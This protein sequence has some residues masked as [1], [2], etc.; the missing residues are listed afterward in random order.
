MCFSNA[1]LIALIEKRVILTCLN[2]TCHSYIWIVQNFLQ[3]D[4]KKIYVYLILISRHNLN[5]RQQELLFLI[6]TQKIS[7]T[8]CSFFK[9]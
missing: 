6:R 3:I 8:T 1:I 4:L 7:L 5:Q 2:D 9:N